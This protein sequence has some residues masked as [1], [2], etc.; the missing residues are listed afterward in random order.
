M[1]ELFQKVQ[2][3]K[4]L[5]DCI[6]QESIVA[7]LVSFLKNIY[8]NRNLIPAARSKKYYIPENAPIDNSKDELISTLT[9]RLA[10]ETREKE[11][12]I[13]N[14]KKTERVGKGEKRKT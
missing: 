14:K 8:T 2:N 10:Q 11:S 3:K 9:Q 5:N 4:Y 7:H 1:V 6:D 12:N 13:K